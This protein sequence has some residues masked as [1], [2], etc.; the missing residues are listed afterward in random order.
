MVSGDGRWKRQQAPD[1]LRHVSSVR[2]RVWRATHKKVFVEL[3]IVRHWLFLSTATPRH[4]TPRHAT[5]RTR[6]DTRTSQRLGPNTGKLRARSA[7]HRSTAQQRTT[8]TGLCNPNS[9]QTMRCG[10]PPLKHHTLHTARTKE[11]A[12]ARSCF[13]GACAQAKDGRE[14]GTPATK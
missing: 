1:R 9:L 2:V 12:S 4:A 5:P 3:Q 14:G 13:W 8:H 6:P 10:M 11:R 7:Q